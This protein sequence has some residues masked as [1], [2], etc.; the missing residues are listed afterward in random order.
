LGW[1]E[2]YGA[3]LYNTANT[4]YLGIKND[5]TPHYSKLNGFSYT[6]YHSGN[7]TADTLGALTTTA[8]AE[9]YLPLSGGTMSGDIV[10]PDGKLIRQNAT[11]G[12]AL[13][14]VV[15]NEVLVGTVDNPL[16]LRSNGTSTINGNAL[17]HSGNIAKQIVEGVFAG[18]GIGDAN[19]VS[20]TDYT[21]RWFS[22]I[23]SNTS[24]IPTYTGY[25]NGL[26]ALPLHSSGT[27]AQLYVTAGGYL[28][29][30][31]T[32]T[33]AW[34]QLAFTD[35]NVASATKLQTART[36]W[37]QSFD[38]S[39]DIVNPATMSILRFRDIDGTSTSY[40]G[41]GSQGDNSIFIS[42]GNNN[43]F[44]L[45]TNGEERI[46]ATASGNVLIGAIKD[47]G[48]KLAVNG[49]LSAGGTKLTTLT[50]S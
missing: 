15:S 45:L 6:L 5:G 44:I 28:G 40:I 1:Y 8:A 38:G 41:R 29:F 17:I 25:Q 10:L 47:N 37:G 11:N 30:R 31:G 36:I 32:A 26:L 46:K 23:P 18:S 49:T 42:V 20:F 7:L 48:Y 12:S 4:L 24:N 33:S 3:Y 21:L 22:G 2:P 9:T 19:T 43:N 39:A 27:T 34:K 16:K 35:S 50:T 14:G 13:I